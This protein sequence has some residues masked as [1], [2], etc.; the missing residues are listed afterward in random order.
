MQTRSL[1]EQ[2]RERRKSF[3]GLLGSRLSRLSLGS[4]ASSGERDGQQGGGSLKQRISLQTQND[5]QQQPGSRATAPGAVAGVSQESN[6]LPE[7]RLKLAPILARRLE[8]VASASSFSSRSTSSPK[9]GSPSPSHSGQPE[10]QKLPS[11]LRTLE[12]RPSPLVGSSILPQVASPESESASSSARHT[13]TSGHSFE[14]AKRQVDHDLKVFLQRDTKKLLDKLSREHRIVEDED[15]REEQE[16]LVRRVHDIAEECYTCSVDDFKLAVTDIVDILEEDRS[17][18]QHRGIKALYTKLLFILTRC[19][20]LLITEELNL[21]AAEPRERKE[22]TSISRGPLHTSMKAPSKQ[23]R[24]EA[25]SDSILRCHTMPVRAMAD[26]V[27]QLR[28]GEEGEAEGEG[29]QEE[30]GGK[31]GAGRRHR[32]SGADGDGIRAGDGGQEGLDSERFSRTTHT[33]GVTLRNSRPGTGFESERSTKASFVSSIRSRVVAPSTGDSER[34]SSRKYGSEVSFKLG[35]DGTLHQTPSLSRGTPSELESHRGD[36]AWHRSSSAGA[37][38]GS[39]RPTGSSVGRPSGGMSHAESYGLSGAGGTSSEAGMGPPEPPAPSEGDVRSTDTGLAPQSA[40]PSSAAASGSNPPKKP[41]V[42]KQFT[43]KL[44]RTL[45]KV[46]SGRSSSQS[47]KEPSTHSQAPS[48]SSSTSSFL[49][50]ATH[51]LRGSGNLSS[52]RSSRASKGTPKPQLVGTTATAPAASHSAHEASTHDGSAGPPQHDI[53]P[54]LSSVRGSQMPPPQGI[55]LGGGARGHPRTS[56]HVHHVAFTGTVYVGD[57]DDNDDKGGRTHSSAQP[58][59]RHMRSSLQDAHQQAAPPG[60]ARALGRSKSSHSHSASPSPPSSLQFPPGLSSPHN[61]GSHARARSQGRVSWGGEHVIG[62]PQQ[63]DGAKGAHHWQQEPSPSV[64]AARSSRS[65]HT[66]PSHGT[67]VRFSVAPSPPSSSS[68]TSEGPLAPQGSEN[69]GTGAKQHLQHKDSTTSYP[70]SALTKESG[71]SAASASTS[72]RERDYERTPP[73][74]VPIDALGGGVR[75]SL[76]SGVHGSWDL[77]KSTSRLAAAAA[78][79][80]AAVAAN[81]KTPSP[82]TVAELRAR[83]SG[84]WGPWSPGPTRTESAGVRSLKQRQGGRSLQAVRT[85]E[86]EEKEEEEVRSSKQSD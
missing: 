5:L 84:N 32:L 16:E 23:E 11:L 6:V 70:D 22:G 63:H 38:T 80:T 85:G 29:L 65:T 24:K 36:H 73:P 7:D 82:L 39:S 34:A 51:F 64:S 33:S 59:S 20:R 79:A 61:R 62:P 31:D 35:G 66:R 58:L 67:R 37:R 18:I 55:L 19:S 43:S 3:P 48:R 74:S 86:E 27:Q 75:S 47:K 17:L 77:S 15:M 2:G 72:T 49:S 25:M 46:G 26:I 44:V 12:G 57:D 78:A 14:V 8:V 81:P 53:S 30:Q 9:S 42:L 50:S 45:S 54:P 69:L 76:R 4:D 68:A 71:G 13:P 83:G 21:F 41:G 28:I 56:P 40:Q 10:L 60:S 52:P 1:H